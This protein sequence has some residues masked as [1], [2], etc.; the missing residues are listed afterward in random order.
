[1]IKHGL[2]KAGT[3]EELDVRRKAFVTL[4][5]AAPGTPF[6]DQEWAA[7]QAGAVQ[8]LKNRRKAARRAQAGK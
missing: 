1:M 2:L 4:D 6:S 7:V 8:R 5:R 3:K